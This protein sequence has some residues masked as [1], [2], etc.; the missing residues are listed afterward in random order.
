MMGERQYLSAEEFRREL[1][2]SSVFE[3]FRDSDDKLLRKIAGQKEEVLDCLESLYE[4]LDR[5]KKPASRKEISKYLQK[6]SRKVKRAEDIYWGKEKYR[7]YAPVAAATAQ[8]TGEVLGEVY[9]PLE[10]VLEG[11][12]A[13]LVIA[14]WLVKRLYSKRIEEHQPEL[15]H[16]LKMGFSRYLEK[17]SIGTYRPIN[18]KYNKA[19]A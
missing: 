10:F 2:D 5:P 15:A 8:L 19:R 4:C 9:K 18:C 13:A 12:A 16:A 14:P 17:L 3:A 7:K 11:V 6:L 1:E